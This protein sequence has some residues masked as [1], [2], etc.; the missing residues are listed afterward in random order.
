MEI[1]I[2]C[3]NA[4]GKAKQKMAVVLPPREESPKS[5]GLESALRI[6]GRPPT[7]RTYQK[8]SYGKLEVRAHLKGA[9]ESSSPNTG[10]VFGLEP[11]WLRISVPNWIFVKIDTPIR[12]NF[13]EHDAQRRS[14][15]YSWQ[16][17][18]ILGVVGYS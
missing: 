10:Q 17:E 1:E 5:Y 18:A 6:E 14:S 4:R 7:G 13:F 2:R 11:K 16:L 8:A 15:V 3:R 9:T 12:M